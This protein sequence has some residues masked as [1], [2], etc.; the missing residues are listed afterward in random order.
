MHAEAPPAEY[1]P[2]EQ[3]VGLIAFWDDMYP[4]G[5]AINAALPATGT[6]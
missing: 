3:I 4:G 1:V 6:K 2:A 5:T